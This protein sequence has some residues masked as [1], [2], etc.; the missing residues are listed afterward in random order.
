M[1]HINFLLLTII[2]LLA[3]V[4]VNAAV[5][6]HPASE[7]TAGTFGAGDFTFIGNVNIKTTTI[8]ALLNID[9]VSSYSAID[10]YDNS[11]NKWGIG[12]NPS[13]K[14]YIETDII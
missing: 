9:S 4:S 8:S 10:F 13:N 6:S 7:I 2:S 14:F 11:V 12:K 5:V 1:K 3:L